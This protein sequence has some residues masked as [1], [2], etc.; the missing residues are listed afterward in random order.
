M[1]NFKVVNWEK[2]DG[3]PFLRLEVS[4][5]LVEPISLEYKFTPD[6]IAAGDFVG[7]LAQKVAE[8]E[9]MVDASKYPDIPDI[10]EVTSQLTDVMVSDKKAVVLSKSLVLPQPTPVIKVG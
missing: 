7:L 9:V 5:G 4:E 3:V 2:K 8:L 1:I 10:D 6:D